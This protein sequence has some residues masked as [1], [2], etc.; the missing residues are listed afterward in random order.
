MIGSFLQQNF[1]ESVSK[2]GYGIYCIETDIY[3][4]VDMINPKPFLLFKISSFDD[5][6]DGSETL[7]NL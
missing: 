3:E 2:H 7:V 6:I 4:F 1:G 5:L